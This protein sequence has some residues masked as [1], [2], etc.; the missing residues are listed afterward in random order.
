M[1][2]L[3]FITIV[4]SLFL[5]LGSAVAENQTYQEAIEGLD[6]MDLSNVDPE[7]AGILRKYYKYTYGDSLTWESIESLKYKGNLLA[8]G[9]SYQYTA[10]RKR[11]DLLK[12]VID[13]NK[14]ESIILG[15][16]GKDA[17]QL[18]N[19]V[20][21]AEPVSMPDAEARNFIR[22]AAFGGHLLYPQ[23]KGKKFEFVGTSLVE[24][25]R[26][27]ELK[28]TLPDGQVIRS[29]FDMTSFA[30]LYKITVNNVNGSEELEVCTDFRKVGGIRVPFSS[31]LKV[32][33]EQMHQMRTSELLI[34]KGVMRWVFRRS[35]HTNLLPEADKTLE[36]ILS[37]PTNST[38]AS[39]FS[40]EM[41]DIFPADAGGVGSVFQ[42]ESFGSEAGAQGS[43]GSGVSGA[44]NEPQ[45]V[46]EE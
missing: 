33:G 41:N 13:L 45:N 29:F 9:Q 30:E 42:I 32:N 18:S 7:V 15:Y 19:Q 11:P 14:R 4:L 22:I 2:R 6:S 35:R 21:N 43:G 40:F 46:A 44:L 20:P 24:G 1:K 38:Q 26:V 8:G 36:A 3:T 10:Y 12:V 5:C 25:D 37:S 27:Y 17:W 28:T 23:L 31:T 39:S 16:D 34:N